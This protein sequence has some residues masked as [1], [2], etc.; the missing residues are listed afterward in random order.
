M[1]GVFINIPYESEIEILQPPPAEPFNIPTHAISDLL[2]FSVA[3]NLGNRV[4]AH[5][6]VTLYRPGKA[7]FLQSEN[8]SV[9]AQ[10]QQ[11]TSEITV[12]DEVD[13]VGFATM[14]PYL[15]ELQNATFHRT[16]VGA[17]PKP[18]TLSATAALRGH[19]ERDIMF[20]SYDGDLIV[21][22]GETDWPFA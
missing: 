7:I 2:R 9:F 18:L 21:V 4:K 15:P 17:T 14:G 22:T 12:G 19:F 6:V 5:G 1:T 8:G 10:T 3:G 20:Q 11:N 13:L 16:G